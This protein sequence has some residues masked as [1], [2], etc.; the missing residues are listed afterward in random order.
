MYFYTLQTAGDHRERKQEKMMSGLGIAIHVDDEAG[1]AGERTPF[2]LSV[3]DADN[4]DRFDVFRL[5]E[6]LC[7]D[8]FLEMGFDEKREYVEKRLAGLK[9]LTGFPMG[10]KTA[11]ELWRSRLSFCISFY[12]KLAG[13]LENS[14]CVL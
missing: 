14:R 12:E 3:G 9:K 2:A 5:H 13:Q 11:E 10:T 1:F 4:I 6:T 7:G 8:G